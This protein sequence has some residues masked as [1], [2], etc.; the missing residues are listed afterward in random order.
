MIDAGD[1]IVAIATPPGRGA[2]GVVRVSGP[3]T[4][5]IARE[6]LGR[7]PPPRHAGFRRFLDGA[8]E[9]IDEGVALTFKA[10]AS[11]TGEDVLE[12]YA[13]GSPVVLD[14]LVARVT[15]LGARPAG[16]GEFSRRAFLNGKYDLAQLEAVADLI[17]S[18]SVA[19][20]RCAQRSLQGE[21]SSQVRT[22][23]D[24][25]AELRAHVEAS[26]DF[27][28]ED[29]AP[30]QSDELATS[31]R[32]M[33]AR[34]VELHRRTRRG[35]VLRT[36]A[37]IVIAGQPN[38]GKSSLLNRLA[39]REE[40]IVSEFAGT[41]RD[42][43]KSDVLVGQ[44]PVRV[45]DTAGLRTAGDEIE[46]EGVR[47]ARAACRHADLVL[48][49]VDA[50]DGMG[51]IEKRLATEFDNDGV[52]W[53]AVHNKQDLVSGDAADDETRVSAKTGAGLDALVEQIAARLSGT[54]AGD[55]D[56]AFI[57]RRRHLTALAEAE[58]AIKE[59]GERLSENALELS[60]ENLRNA[61]QALSAITGVRTNEDLLE[62]IFS[63]FCIG[64]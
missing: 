3:Q 46:Q 48:L 58:R 37:E 29:I 50:R 17:A 15:E 61:Q 8:G 44:V 19:A 11:F 30:A 39:G 52:P 36:G 57:A 25:L 33:S 23:G 13:H 32:E 1:T 56:D 7:V 24:E 6:L 4:E 62:D 49:V 45:L 34:I 31:L 20:V 60:A 53:L 10:P 16:P 5:C 41:T 43:L 18:A 26:L 21:F 28:D 38:V 35:A 12:L 2:I 59:A 22:I 55:A 64:K 63:R 14:Q 40:A 47:R 42:V 54:D 27:S 51:E 9:I